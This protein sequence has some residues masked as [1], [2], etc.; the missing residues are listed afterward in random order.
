MRRHRH[1]VTRQPGKSNVIE[2]TARQV[3]AKLADMPPDERV[4]VMI[5][6]PGLGVIARRLPAIATANGMTDEIHDDLLGS[7]RNDR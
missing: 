5:G 2:G 4:R 3:I 7:L 6:R 1:H